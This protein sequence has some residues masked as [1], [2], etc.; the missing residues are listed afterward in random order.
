MLN[1]P[2]CTAPVTRTDLLARRLLRERTCRSCGGGYFEGGTTVGVGMIAAAGMVAAGLD[3]GA[4]LPEWAPPVILFGTAVV[5]V[6]YTHGCQPRKIE[7]VR[8]ALVSILLVVPVV[9]LVV[10]TILRAVSP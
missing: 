1:C 10:R 9:A 8:S 6:R 3:A 5:A 2:H 7:E 4:Q